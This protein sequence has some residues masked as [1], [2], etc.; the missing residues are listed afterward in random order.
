VNPWPGQTLEIRCDGSPVAFEARGE[1]VEFPTEADKVYEVHCGRPAAAPSPPMPPAEA[2]R[3]LCYTGPALLGDVP[4]E[5][6][7]K[8]WLGIPPPATAKGDH[9]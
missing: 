8:V 3:P 4:P 6:R 2:P 9:S 5:K 1:I 7:I